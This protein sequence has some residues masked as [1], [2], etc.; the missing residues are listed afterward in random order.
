MNLTKPNTSRIEVVDALRGFAIM[1]IM[2]LHSIEHFNFYKFPANETQSAWL[3]ALDSNIWNSLFFLFGGKAY[4]IFAVLFGFTFSLMMNNQKKRG[5]DFG[6]R[7]L[8]RMV[9]LA[10][11]A[12]I[13]GMFFPG[14]VLLMYSIVGVGL[15]FVRNLSNR[16]LLLIA[17]FF[18]LQPVEWG[19]LIYYWFDNSYTIGRPASWAL[20]GAL[21]EGQLSESFYECAKACTLNGH[22]VALYWA[23]EVG[24]LAQTVGLFVLGLWLGR[25]NLFEM[26][27]KNTKFWLRTV[28]V[29]F[30]VFFPFYWLEANFKTLFENKIY[31]QTLKHAIDMYGNFAFCMFLISLF[32]LLFQVDFFRKPLNLLRYCGKMSLTAYVLQSI[33]GGLVFY[34]WGFGLGP[35]IKHTVSILIGIV[36]FIVQFQFYKFWL[37]KYKRGPLETIW[38]KLT[39]IKISK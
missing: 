10:G 2:L 5:F 15:F 18:L 9:L 20:W 25:K 29:S 19:K 16:V 33:I 36:L 38:H 17:T 8:W 1:A 14:E 27:D 13:N 34:G 6:Y 3:N 30:V 37:T 22:K 11:F 26:N 31:S 12:F 4:A 39:W 35:H 28:V 32:V 7:H 24:R 23:Y 21:K